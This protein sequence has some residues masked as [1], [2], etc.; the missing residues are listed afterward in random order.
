MTERWTAVVWPPP[1]FRTRQL[2]V[3]VPLLTL[4]PLALGSAAGATLSS[5]LWLSIAVQTVAT[6][7]GVAAGLEHDRLGGAVTRG[8]DGGLWFGLGLLGAH[9]A[10]GG[11]DH[12]L[13][14]QPRPLQ[15]VVTSS[16]GALLGLVGAM[17]RRRAFP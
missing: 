2:L 5:Y 16:V 17:V 4:V 15:L 10:I 1:L 13:L 14:A 8:I 9:A 11:S 12:G 7:G 6:F 3:R